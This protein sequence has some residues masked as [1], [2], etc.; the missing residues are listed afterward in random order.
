MKIK[1]A[2]KTAVFVMICA[3]LLLNGCKDVE[4]SP[5]S[6]AEVLLSKAN[7]TDGAELYGLY[8]EGCHDTLERSS[9]A[10]R[11]SAAIQYA[12]ETN[13]G[14]AQD[15][16]MGPLSGIFG[17]DS[18]GQSNIAAVAAVLETVSLT[19]P[20]ASVT[21]EQLYAGYCGG[22]HGE[23]ATT[24]KPR[25]NREATVYAASAVGE[26]SF[27]GLVPATV[28][29]KIGTV[30]EGV[31]VSLPPTTGAEWYSDFC[32]GCHGELA[33]SEKRGSSAA[34]IRNS[35]RNPEMIF[36]NTASIPELTDLE[37]DKIAAALDQ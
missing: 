12:I 8:C 3:A 27:L 30:M 13:S 37:I 10:K 19:A 2:S 1:I 31:A 22:C 16:Y 34:A 24:N 6:T 14:N 23:L 9:K 28:L 26:M 5:D 25:R 29:A 20:A 18:A 35:F 17:S 7:V 36:L 11:S 15:G 32:M 4:N 33:V 21:G